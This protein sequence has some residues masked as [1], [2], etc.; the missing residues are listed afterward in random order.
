[1]DAINV[2]CKIKYS[3]ID[4]RNVE[5]AYLDFIISINKYAYILF[6]KI[7]DFIFILFKRDVYSFPEPLSRII[8]RE[9]RET[10]IENCIIPQCAFVLN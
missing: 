5:S 10:A 9:Q 3:R 2:R 6:L 1:M 7:I 8:K 4:T